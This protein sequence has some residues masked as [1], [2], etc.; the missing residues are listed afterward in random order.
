MMGRRIIHREHERRDH[1]KRD[2]ELTIQILRSEIEYDVD[3]ST[4]KIAEMSDRKG[5]AQATMETSEETSDWLDRQI[6]DMIDEIKTVC[7][8]YQPHRES[9]AVTNEAGSDKEWVVSLIMEPGWRGEPKRVASLMHRYIV[10][11]I[12]SAWYGM[13][14]PERVEYYESLKSDA[15]ERL[16]GEIRA[17]NMGN[18]YFRF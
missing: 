16:I 14:A 8:A 6:N 7:S 4:W 12:L 5:K 9:R 15:E 13:V 1:T 10:N 2:Y 11:G 17:V 18:I 3:Y